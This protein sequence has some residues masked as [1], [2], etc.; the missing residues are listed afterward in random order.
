[1]ALLQKNQVLELRVLELQ[2]PVV[3]EHTFVP[4]C[5]VEQGRAFNK[6]LNILST[7]NVFKR[8]LQTQTNSAF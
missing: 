6:V 3:Q 1:M 8:I 5:H 7:N 2:P 4:L